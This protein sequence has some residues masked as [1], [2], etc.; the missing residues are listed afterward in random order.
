MPNKITQAV[1]L[2]AGLGT[3]LREVTGDEMPKVMAPFLG[4][5]ILEKHIERLKAHG[6]EDFFINLFYL[7]E[8][9]QSYFEDGSKWGVKITYCLEAP[10]IRGTAGGIKD[11]EG[12]LK[13]DFFVIY[14]DVYNEIDYAKME[15]AFAS[16]KG[17]IAITT[18]GDND[19]PQDSDL[20]EV[21]SKSRFTKIHPKPHAE[22]PKKYKAMRAAAFI[23]NEKILKYIPA[24]AYYEIDHQL[25]PD[26]MSKRE[27]VYGYEPGAYE[28]IKDIGTPERYKETTEHLK[29][30]KP[31]Q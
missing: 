14:G 3:R 18:I 20:V 16:H 21:D 10:E 23:F 27:A 4:K 11:F 1:I 15:T 30:N 22:L 28:F 6:I 25:L 9:I 13:G 26:V 17:A 7:P 19:H 24:N 31:V 29:K 8:K 12:K 2:S 5:P